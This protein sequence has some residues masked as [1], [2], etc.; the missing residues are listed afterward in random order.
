MC[1]L[2]EWKIKTRKN[3]ELFEKLVHHNLNFQYKNT[4]DDELSN[5]VI[6]NLL[7]KIRNISILKYAQFS[8]NSEL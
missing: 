3:M 1:I 5:G 2:I 6:N 8:K 4:I 7:R